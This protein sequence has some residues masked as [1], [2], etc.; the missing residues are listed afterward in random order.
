MEV[1]G[2]LHTPATEN[3]P[4]QPLN[5]RL[6]GPQSRYR[7]SGQKSS[8]P[9]IV[10]KLEFQNNDNFLQPLGR[11]PDIITETGH[12]HFFNVTTYNVSIFCSWYSV[13]MAFC[14]SPKYV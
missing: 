1:I 7:T 13:I 11:Y 9:Q 6:G 5:R 14:Q 3:S 4:R 10:V 12:G 2:Q 8:S